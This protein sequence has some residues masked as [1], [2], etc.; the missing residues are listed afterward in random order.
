MGC[1]MS[2]GNGGRIKMRRLSLLLTTVALCAGPDSP[3]PVPVGLHH[4]PPK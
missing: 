3:D 1:D 2:L 4:L